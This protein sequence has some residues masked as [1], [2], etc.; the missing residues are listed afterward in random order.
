MDFQTSRSDRSN[1]LTYQ[2]YQ[3][4]GILSTLGHSSI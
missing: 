4:L 3:T 1:S 2:R